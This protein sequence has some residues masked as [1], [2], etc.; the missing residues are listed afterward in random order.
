MTKSKLKLWMS[1]VK[2]I[3][4]RKMSLIR[5]CVWFKRLKELSLEIGQP[6]LTVRKISEDLIKRSCDL[7]RMLSI[8]IRRRRS[9]TKSF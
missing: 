8:S 5:Y 3:V 2:T 7:R 4:N 9:C 6:S 1:V